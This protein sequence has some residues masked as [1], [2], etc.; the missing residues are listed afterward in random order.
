MIRIHR[1]TTG[2]AV[3]LFLTLLLAAGI[4]LGGLLVSAAGPVQAAGSGLGEV[5]EFAL[6]LA[7]GDDHSLMVR[8]DGTL[9]TWGRNQC[10]QLG[11]GDNVTREVPTQVGSSTDWV[12]VAAG[13]NH[14]LALRSDGTLWAWGQANY[15][16][17]GLGDASYKNTPTQVGS[18]TS[19]V[20]VAGGGDS[21][22]G[23]RSD[24]TL[25]SWGFNNHGQL[26][27]GDTDNRL[28]PTQVGSATDWVAVDGGDYHALGLRSD[29][30]LY[31]WG[32]NS[33]GQLGLS[34]VT[35][36][37]SP[38]RVGSD[39]DWVAVVA[40]SFHSLGLRS[41]GTLWSWGQNFSGQLG[42]EDTFIRQSPQQVGSATDWVQVAAGIYHTHGLRSDGTLYSWGDNEYG[43]LGLGDNSD[44]TVPEQ[45]PEA[46][47]AVAGPAGGMHS[48]GLGCDGALFS[49]GRNTYGQLGLGDT[50]DRD[51]PTP[52]GVTLASPPSVSTL[53]ASDIAQKAAT[54]NGDVLSVG[55]PD[56][57]A[58]AAGYNHALGLRSDGTLWAWG[59]NY[60]GQLGMGDT[61]QRETPAQVGASDNW[62][63]IS[64]CGFHSLGL[65]SDGTVWSWG[66][67][68]SGQLGLGD[69]TQRPSP[70]QV[71]TDNTWVAVSAGTGFSLG[72]RSDGTLWAW[73]SNSNGQLGVGD[74]DNRLAPEQ[75]GT[76]TDWVA[77]HAGYYHSLGLRSDGTLWSWGYN[78]YGQ[79]GLGVAD[80]T[81]RESPE[82]V[83]S[84]T[85]WVAASGGYLHSL[86]LRSDG[87][88][89]SWGNNDSYQLGYLGTGRQAPGQ[90]GTDTDWVAVCAGGSHSLGLC[91]DGTL[92]G[93]G[94]NGSGELGL[95]DKT[96][97]SGPQEIGAAYS[98][99]TPSAGYGFSLGL[100]ADGTLW[101]TGYNF[102]GQLGL[103]DTSDRMAMTKV[104][105]PCQ[106]WF[107]WGL[108][109]AYGNATTP[110]TVSAAGPID[111]QVSGLVEGQTYNYRACFAGWR[112]VAG[113]NRVFTTA[114]VAP[115]V[116][117]LVSPGNGKATSDNT[118]W[119]DWSDVMD[120]SGVRHQLQ[121]DDKSDFS[122]PE[123]NLTSLRYSSYT[124]PV[125][126]D[127][128]F[129]WRAG[130]VDGVGNASGWTD[131]WTFNVDTKAPPVP[132]LKAPADGRITKDSTP[133]LDW[134]D[135]LDV[136]SVH[137]QLQVD[138]DK[139]FSSPTV[140]RTWLNGSS[141]S[142]DT[143]LADG[144][145]Y[146]RVR[147]VDAAG[148]ASAWSA[149]WALTV[150]TTAPP[151]PE[152]VYPSNGAVTSDTTPWLDWSTVVDA[153]AVHYQLQLDETADFATPVVSRTWLNGSSW[154]VDTPLP[155]GVYY[156]RVRAVDA[157]GNASAWTAAWT[158]TVDATTPP[159]PELVSPSNGALT[160][161]ST[162]WLDWST[163]TDATAVHYQ[164]QA[165]NDADF[166]S[167]AVTKTWLNGS[168]WSVDAMLPD[169]VYYWRVRAVD[170]A[171]NA[172]VWTA[173]WGL[174]VDTTAPPVPE[175]VYPSNG[176]VTSDTTPWLDWS[177]VTDATAVHYQLQVDNDA[178]FTSPVVSKTWLNGSSWSVDTVLP[179]GVYYWRVR[180]VDAAGNAS[181][182][183]GA[184]TFTIQ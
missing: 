77:V 8:S 102:Y 79:L 162:P 118:P 93:W 123:V 133:W 4:V 132:G 159:V 85:S 63:A 91:A 120:P 46:R 33:S 49:W 111:E 138:D 179:D 130:A 114:V 40:G 74:T 97:R 148:N 175:L 117:T 143:A 150:D 105:R 15:G 22:L 13:S 126:A 83:G 51:S 140:S 81:D 43:Q 34:D 84:G 6:A 172:S 115:A 9:W 92:W 163:V 144:L 78:E 54:L 14:S 177:A 101:S 38:E 61:T 11:L 86:G 166:T 68:S 39:N 119:L 176:G 125:M 127:G 3:W 151:V 52:V 53:P 57:A 121:V 18:A 182:W 25:W 2:G 178:D 23:L 161:D 129:Y 135:V 128:T 17:L 88:I 160:T 149:A 44:R 167:P 164:L 183:T 158:L 180:A 71:G 29:G 152:L 16:Q 76:G 169:G 7:A 155:D 12:E 56:F 106:A 87:T 94:E 75:V 147:A 98:W 107:E 31:A 157:A 173:A 41:G 89:W 55:Q 67:N 116:P 145:Y 170:A 136:T 47:G 137:Y 134:G 62:V 168:S 181:A 72:L 69:T 58:V 66:S 184:W 26:G 42:L 28:S 156:W 122:S 64:A 104:V 36:R 80:T 90:V 5:G 19:W 142:V 73:G 48:L 99:V 70:T 24:G 153:T 108:T 35:Q 109:T 96:D 37:E 141:W 95:G 113:E 59:R 124:L 139:D 27:L 154:S 32:Y 50:T 1:L 20:A 82:Q 30:S 112:T 174:T 165:D 171:G 131:A 10:Y 103:G 110:L 45:V 100:Q 65:Q 60:E 146:W 21:S